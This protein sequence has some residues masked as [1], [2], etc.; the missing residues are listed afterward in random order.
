MEIERKF[1]VSSSPGPLASYPKKEILQG[2]IST[3]PVIRIR[4]S[5]EDFFLTCKGKGLLAREEFEI[6]IT[7]LEFEH[8]SSKLDYY[9]IHK[10]RYLVPYGEYTI[11]LDV[12]KDRLDGLLMAEVEFPSLEA[13]HDFD[14]PDWFEAEVTEDC[15]YQNNTLC[16]LNGFDELNTKKESTR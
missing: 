13:A 12:F 1:I 14:V 6:S 15:R 7:A 5:N 8:L 2:Y 9:L 3:S 10:T 16:R 11:E 4:K